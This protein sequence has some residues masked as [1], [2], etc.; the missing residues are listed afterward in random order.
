MRAVISI[1]F[2]I[3]GADGA[4]CVHVNGFRSLNAAVSECVY[5][6]AWCGCWFETMIHNW[7][8]MS[9]CFWLNAFSRAHHSGAMNA[10]DRKRLRVAFELWSTWVPCLR[11]QFIQRYSMFRIISL[12]LLAFFSLSLSSYLSCSLLLPPLL[13]CPSLFPISLPIPFPWSPTRFFHFSVCCHNLLP[14]SCQA[15]GAFCNHKRFKWVRDDGQN[16]TTDWSVCARQMIYLCD[17][18]KWNLISS[19]W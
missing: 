17:V 8:G 12:R 4:Q 18:V 19:I 13:P 7:F 1:P 3:G 2:P 11:L 15:I 6:C 14:A 5:V 9:R 10:A 16:N